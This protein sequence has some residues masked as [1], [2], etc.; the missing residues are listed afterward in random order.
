MCS[1][2]SVEVVKVSQIK[3]F[4][5][6][7]GERFEQQY[8]TVIERQMSKTSANSMQYFASRLAAKTAVLKILDLE[9]NWH[10]LWH[11]IEIQQLSRGEPTIVL[12]AR[13][14]E[15]AAKLGIDRWLLSI[16]HTSC[17]AAASAIAISGF[18]AD[19]NFQ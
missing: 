13:G 11:D 8:F 7:I 19:S 6:Q 1:I 15:I 4:V 2:N 14:Q 17:Y 5:E 3:E 9:E 10:F 12:S 18:E 16:S